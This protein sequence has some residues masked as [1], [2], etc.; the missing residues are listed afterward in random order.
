MWRRELGRRLT[1]LALV[2]AAWCASASGNP[3]Y[4][5]PGSPLKADDPQS[6]ALGDVNGDGHPDL[7]VGVSVL[8][9]TGTGTFAPAP[10]S[11]LK[12]GRDPGSLALADFNGDGHRDLV[13]ANGYSGYVSVLLGAGT[14]AFAPAPGS[15]FKV[16]KGPTSVAVSDLNGDEHPD[17]AVAN[18]DSSDVSVLLGIGTG[19]FASAHGSPLRVGKGPISVALGNLNADQHPD[20]AVVNISSQ[21]VSVLLGTG[22]GTFAPAPG[23]PIKAGRGPSS[24]ALGDLNADRHPDLAVANF[25]SG[26]VS[27]LLGTG[28][29]AFAPA[30]GSPFKAGKY[31]I[32]LA[33]GD[34]NADQHPD[35][36]VANNGSGDVSLLLGTGTGAFAPARGSPLKTRKGSMA[37]V[38]G[39]LNSDQRPDLAVASNDLLRHDLAL[40]R[41]V[42]V[43]LNSVRCVVPTLTHTSLARA[44]RVLTRADCSLGSVRKPHR[45]RR[46]GGLVVVAQ[47]PRAGRVLRAGSPIAVRL[48]PRASV[49]PARRRGS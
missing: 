13:V 41:N 32:A 42:T 21:D 31:P 10:G 28:T 30:R 48:A 29:G 43:L 33:L 38:L 37:V 27:L 4:P 11:P 9:G 26:D 45:R 12:A 23:S 36:A 25:G 14:G 46:G 20:L 19:A 35:L 18:F 1:M 8:L 24:V 34:L 44:R 15:P 16:G 7:V 3:F 2:G 40:A 22:T 39:D 49:T 47:N 6:L 17:V 5:A